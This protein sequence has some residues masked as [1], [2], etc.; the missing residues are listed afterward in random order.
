MLERYRDRG[1][2]G[3]VDVVVE[4]L[5]E[6]EALGYERVMMQHLVHADLETIELIG[7]EVAPKVA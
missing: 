2:V 4:H 6:I 5:R 7:R 1:P 3:T